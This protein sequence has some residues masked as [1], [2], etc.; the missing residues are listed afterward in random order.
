MRSGTLCRVT[1]VSACQSSHFRQANPASFFLRSTAIPR[2]QCLTVSTH[3]FKPACQFKT[4]LSRWEARLSN[5]RALTI[6]RW[7]SAVTS[8][9]DS[10]VLIN[11]LRFCLLDENVVQVREL[12]FEFPQN[13]L[14][15]IFVN[16]QAQHQGPN[17]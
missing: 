3:F 13:S 2:V 5:G 17:G 14:V 15:E 12:E 16:Q 1:P 4:T 6:N 8:H 7:P 11:A 9:E 10:V